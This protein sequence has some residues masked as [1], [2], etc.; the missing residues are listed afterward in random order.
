MDKKLKK[1]IIIFLILSLVAVGVIIYNFM[2]NK[3]SI[4]ELDNKR[5]EEI[6]ENEKKAQEEKNNDT[7]LKQQEDNMKVRCQA[8]EDMLFSNKDEKYDEVIKMTTEIIKKYPDSYRAY[9]LRGIAYAY[10]TPINLD[11]KTNAFMDIDKALS[12]KPDYGYGRF[13]KAL[14]YAILCDYENA[15]KWYDNA[16]EIESY[17][18]SYYGKGAIYAKLGDAENSVKWLKKA[19]ELKP[20]IKELLKKESEFDKIRND[21]RFKELISE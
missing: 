2:S 18:W 7:Q 11:F 19:L 17:H 13:N 21:S 16:L 12:I 6:E 14:A 8:A 9:S 20:N 15:L 5:I 10:K 1:K 3:N 4:A